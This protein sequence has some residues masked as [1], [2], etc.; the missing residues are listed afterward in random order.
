MPMDEIDSAFRST[1][2]LGDSFQFHDAMRVVSGRRFIERRELPLSA[3][4]NLV[5]GPFT[6]TTG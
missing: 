2:R 1:M 4:R 3:R 6:L 5:F